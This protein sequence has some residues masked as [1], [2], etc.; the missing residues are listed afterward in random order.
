MIKKVSFQLEKTMWLVKMFTRDVGTE[1]S[2]V[3][4]AHNH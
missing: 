4:K 2:S 1:T 3:N